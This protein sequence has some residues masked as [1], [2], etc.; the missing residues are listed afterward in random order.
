MV[1]LNSVLSF[2]GNGLHIQREVYAMFEIWLPYVPY[3]QILSQN[4]MNGCFWVSV[5]TK[6]GRIIFWLYAIMMDT[7]THS[8]IKH[9]F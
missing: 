1:V 5:L 4:V 2:E 6:D 7:H 9:D 3:Y 8:I